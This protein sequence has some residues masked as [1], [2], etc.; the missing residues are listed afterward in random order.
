MRQK[1]ARSRG[2]VTISQGRSDYSE[3]FVKVFGARQDIHLQ[4]D[5]RFARSV[6]ECP[7]SILADCRK[8]LGKI[9]CLVVLRF[10][11]RIG[12][13]GMI[14]GM[15]PQATLLPCCCSCPCLPSDFGF[16]SVPGSRKMEE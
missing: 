9:R 15:V 2:S 10:E 11:M 4:L 5:D 8:S 16:F 1:L 14:G 6:N 12:T 7:L 3:S 13:V